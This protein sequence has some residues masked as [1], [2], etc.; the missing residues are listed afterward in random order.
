MAWGVPQP[1]LFLKNGDTVTVE[2]E[3]IG[4]LENQQNDPG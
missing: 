4:S 3:N 1:A 2:V